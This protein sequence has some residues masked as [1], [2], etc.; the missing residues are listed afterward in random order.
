[1]SFGFLLIAQFLLMS[2]I[3]TPLS[4]IPF[5]PFLLSSRKKRQAGTRK[6]GKDRGL[7]K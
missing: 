2:L 4:T 5:F 3:T 7:K 6:N 1:M